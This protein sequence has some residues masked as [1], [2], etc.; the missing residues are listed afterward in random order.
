M[1]YLIQF[2]V[3]SS[4]FCKTLPELVTHTTPYLLQH[5]VAIFDAVCVPSCCVCA[6]DSDALFDKQLQT[7]D[8]RWVEF[9]DAVVS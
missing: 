3:A 2:P 9:S 7:L 1:Q 4:A 8:V 6:Q 5:S